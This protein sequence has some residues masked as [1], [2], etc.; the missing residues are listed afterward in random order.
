MVHFDGGKGKL[1]FVVS[2][3]GKIVWAQGELSQLKTHNQTEVEALVQAVNYVLIE[4]PALE[5]QY[6]FV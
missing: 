3:K 5:L 6:D 4:V 1:G 2:L